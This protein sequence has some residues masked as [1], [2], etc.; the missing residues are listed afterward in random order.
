M[1]S[2]KDPQLQLLQIEISTPTLIVKAMLDEKVHFKL[3][4]QSSVG[5][6]NLFLTSR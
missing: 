3:T 5:Y 1:Y 4:W 2:E 6:V